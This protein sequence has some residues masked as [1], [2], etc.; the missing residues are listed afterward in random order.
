MTL[1]PLGSATG[2]LVFHP[3]EFLSERNLDTRSLR[4]S[5]TVVHLEGMT[6]VGNTAPGK[7]DVIAGVRD[8]LNMLYT[9]SSDLEG[10]TIFILADTLSTVN[11]ILKIEDETRAMEAEQ[12]KRYLL[13]MVGP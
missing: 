3:S 12:R 1:S 7:S 10:R 13:A 11:W 9:T 5:T 6:K 4:V 8:A 2:M